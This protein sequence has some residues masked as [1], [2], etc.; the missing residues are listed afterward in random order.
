MAVPAIKIPFNR[1]PTPKYFNTRNK[2]KAI[3][4]IIPVRV[5]ADANENVNRKA[6][7]TK[8]RKSST[9]IN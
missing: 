8:T 7:K 2:V 1:F 9:N 5:F 6:K 4:R 3:A